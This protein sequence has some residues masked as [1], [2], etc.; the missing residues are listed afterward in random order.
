MRLHKADL[1][2]FRLI[3]D[4]LDKGACNVKVCDVSAFLL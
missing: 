2:R 1:A 4:L 3:V